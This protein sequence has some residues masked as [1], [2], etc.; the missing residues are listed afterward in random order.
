MK[1]IISIPEVNINARIYNLVTIP[2]LGGA[3]VGF[4]RHKYKTLS[5]FTMVFEHF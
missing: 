2:L 1:T 3:G 5:A 4:A